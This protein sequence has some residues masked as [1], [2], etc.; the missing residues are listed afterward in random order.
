M[1]T[2]ADKLNRLIGTKQAIKEAIVS[3]GVGVSDQDTFRSY[4][5][6]IKAI[7]GGASTVV[8]DN[9]LTFHDYD[10]TILYS[11]S[12][13]EAANLTELPPL[14]QHEGLITQG[15]CNTLDEIKTSVKTY[16]MCQVGAYYITDD[17][18]TRLYFDITTNTHSNMQRT[19]GLYIGSSSAYEF[20]VD[21]G[22]GTDKVT[23]TGA[24]R[25]WQEVTHK[26]SK[27]G[28]YKVS[29]KVITGTLYLTDWNSS[30]NCV[31]N[32]YIGNYFLK[33]VELGS[34]FSFGYTPFKNCHG[35]ETITFPKRGSL[36]F[37]VYSFYCCYSLKFI[38][39]NNDG[40]LKG[41]AFANNY[42]LQAHALSRHSLGETATS[43][44]RFA[45]CY[46]LRKATFVDTS[47]P[48]EC[49][50]NCTYLKK[51]A[52][53]SNLATISR[54]AFRNC[55]ALESINL[56]SVKTISTSAFEGCHALKRVKMSKCTSIADSCFKD[57]FS[58]DYIDFTEA[59]AA[60]SI[61]TTFIS[62]P[63][64][65]FIVPPQLFDTWI[66]TSNWPSFVGRIQTDVEPTEVLEMSIEGDDIKA[67]ET[68]TRI[69]INAKVNGYKLTTGEYVENATLR[70]SVSGIGSLPK[71]TTSLPVMRMVSYTLLG[72]TAT[73]SITQAAAIDYKIVCKYD[74]TDTSAATQLL[75][76]SYATHATD[77]SKMFI[78][79][80]EY[81]IALSHQFET[82]GEHEVIFKISSEK[83]Q[84]DNAYSMFYNCSKLTSI[85][86]SLWD[87]SNLTSA[88]TSAGTARLFY[89][90]SGLK[91]IVLPDTIKYLGYY[92][93][94]LCVN[95]TSLT[96][97]ATTAPSVYS[98]S[99]WGDGTYYIGYKNRT[100]GINKLYVPKGATGYATG[101]WSSYLLNTSYCGF[102]K[103]DIVTIPEGY[104]EVMASNG[105]VFNAKDGEFYVKQ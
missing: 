60:P 17:G 22:D 54:Y 74:V 14:P 86:C 73:A 93:F 70:Y 8:S 9:D 35:L 94:R 51:V 11:Y 46:S 49:F 62:S 65:T 101:T 38:C 92:M 16:G 90:C 85:D 20:E 41:Y 80:V 24:A 48:E 78:D 71:N 77:F 6:K 25:E 79:G 27:R 97:K 42:N 76:S 10:G 47:V 21:F 56:E 98:S 57:C 88:S 64:T 87:M 67:Y 89:G 7:D 40:G 19:I 36:T 61:G 72:K 59:T 2:T 91:T 63:L 37:S 28:F 15:W 82:T 53:S 69:Y 34:S 84:I 55:K 44:A 83:G 99:T 102:T 52:L 23:V 39:A 95:V 103:T 45:H 96:I 68:S 30:K 81:P 5:D 105:E 32:Y 12:K 4:A 1:G 104:E 13:E 31:A 26:Y 50:D 29:I 100:A 18:C 43:L 58:I 33:K 75:Y 66:K 3:K